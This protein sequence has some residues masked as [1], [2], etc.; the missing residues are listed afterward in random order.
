VLTHASRARDLDATPVYLLGGA[1]ERLG[2]AYVAAPV[3]DECGMVGRWAAEQAFAM[4]GLSPADVD[5]CE[6]YDPF[7]FEIIRQF[8]AYGFCGEGEGGDFGWAAASRSAA[9]ARS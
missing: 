6:F 3:W 2:M 5:V 7:S 1:L 4:C 9:S 8:E